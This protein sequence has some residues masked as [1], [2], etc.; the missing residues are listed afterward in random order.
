MDIQTIQTFIKV[1]QLGS[2]SKAAEKSFLSQR[3]VSKQI[4]QLELELGM[5]LFVRGKNKITL[6]PE[7]Q[8]FLYS[9]EDIV[10]SYINAMTELTKFTKHGQTTFKIGYFSA[11]EGELLEKGLA[12]LLF[13]N[14]Q[15]NLTVKE[16]S[17]EHLLQSLNNDTLDAALSIN[18]GKSQ[19]T[20]DHIKTETIY[21]GEMVFGVSKLN[22]LS[23]QKKLIPADIKDQSILY[24][25]PENSTY[26]LES[27]LASM[28]FIRNT[29]QI[30]RVTSAEQMHM[31]VATNQ[32]LA[33]YPKGLISSKYMHN[34]ETI[35][36]LPLIINGHI[37]S[38][39]IIFMT[40]SN[41]SISNS[42]V[43]ILKN[44]ISV[45]N[46]KTGSD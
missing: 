27:F 11:F 17:N 36:Y 3:A 22:S 44:I 32:S 26:L 45:N 6:T 34:D 7:G 24:Y 33:L 29:N 8:Y 18:F 38:Y 15:L 1:A 16:E 23:L 14:P 25:S 41:S 28:P 9:A 46:K 4:K 30:Q 39:D 12:K 31:L 43:G 13:N 2:F 20:N 37:N 19:I 5:K 10:S 35:N 42:L 21:T 40:K